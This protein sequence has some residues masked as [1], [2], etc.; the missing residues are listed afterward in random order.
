MCQ[1][2]LCVVGGA[3]VHLASMP[4]GDRRAASGRGGAAARREREGAHPADPL[5]HGSLRRTCRRL[6]PGPCGAYTI[7]G[8]GP[9]PNGTG[10]RYQPPDHWRDPRAPGKGDVV[11]SVGPESRHAVSR[12]RT[13]WRRFVQ[14]RMLWEALRAV[15]CAFGWSAQRAP[16]QRMLP[17]GTGPSSIS[18]TSL[19][20]HRP[21]TRPPGA[22]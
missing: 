10:S 22:R 8:G 20:P 7:V 13:R 19:P 11:G 18:A 5:V 3:A 12:E 21:L 9:E 1:C 15:A 17:P 2:G 4:R 6:G 14:R 16:Q